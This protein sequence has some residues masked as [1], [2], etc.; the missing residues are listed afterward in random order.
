[1]GN[2]K[3]E[4]LFINVKPIKIPESIHDVLLALKIALQSVSIDN[5]QKSSKS[6]SGNDIIDMYEIDK[7]DAI[8]AQ[9]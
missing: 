9:V 4:S 7:V 1:M 6:E 3:P 8:T 5:V 2:A